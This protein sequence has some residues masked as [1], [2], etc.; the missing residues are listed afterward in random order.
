MGILDAYRIKKSLAVLVAAQDSSSPAVS[1]AVARLKNIGRTSAAKLID[2]FGKAQTPAPLAEVLATFLDNDTFPFFS[3]H[4]THANPRIAE[5][6]TQVFTKST[7]Y[8]AHKLLPLFADPKIPK[9][10]L[11][12][13][14]LA[15][16]DRLNVKTLVA[17]LPNADKDGRVTLLRLLDRSVTEAALP[18]LIQ[19]TRSEDPNIRLNM[20]RILARFHT[21]AVCDALL[22]LLG[23][24]YKNVRQ[25]A[26]EGLAEMSIAIAVAPVCKL[27]RDPE[28]ELQ[29]KAVDVL[30]QRHDPRSAHH[31]LEYLQDSSEPVRRA[32][33]RVLQAIGDVPTIKALLFTTKDK[34]R[35]SRIRAIEALGALEGNTLCEAVFMLLQDQ[36][37]FIRACAIEILTSAKD[38]RAF[39]YLLEALTDKDAARRERAV[40]AL[41]AVGDKRAIPALLQRLQEEPQAN[42]VIIRAL[43]TL[44]ARQAIPPLLTQLHSQNQEVQKETLRAL[45]NLADADSAANVFQAVIGVSGRTDH[46]EIKD[47]AATTAKTLITKF[48][49]KAMTTPSSAKTP[50]A[51]GRQSLLPAEPM[52]P[53]VVVQ[54]AEVE[55][56]PIQAIVSELP[57]DDQ[58]PDGFLDPNAFAPGDVLTERY[59]IIRR[60]GQGGF[61]T[62]MLVED[63]MVGEEIILKFLNPS[64]ASEDGMIKRFVHELRYARRITHEN[65]I[66]IHDFLMLEKSYAISMEYFDSHSLGDELNGGV[67]L[68]IKRGL[69]IV[70]D[71]CRGMSAAH[72]VN[73]VHRD[74]K[75]PNILIDDQGVV[76]VVDFGLAALNHAESRLTRTGIL[77]GT[78]TYMAPEQVRSRS[79]DARTDVYSLGVI[80]YEIF[81]GQP[82]YGGDDPMA[83]LFQHVEGKPKPPRQIQADIPAGLEAV[84]LK[85]MAVDPDKRYQSMDALRRGIADLTKQGGR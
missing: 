27:L 37:E 21:E 23:D 61:G 76:K 1:Q 44:G 9:A 16:Q 40:E 50:T 5:G 10:T 15:R 14:L 30:I 63:M 29:A 41:A 58:V 34:G 53:E 18:E 22:P 82:P 19:A 69:K 78:P 33:G 56:P 55:L 75:P 52:M 26:L 24:S 79:I 70:W 80:M 65:V 17:L 28:P 4:L 25:A 3:T 68:Q 57:A 83:V 2:S 77:L 11:G 81:T 43:N 72:Q 85:A 74:L 62:V 47:L 67:P 64:V 31:L 60:V 20:S 8:D 39:T 32:A 6:M 7:T 66:R 73:V 38:D 51:S 84:I 35:G 48:G 49:E 71:I 46:H 13:C 54:P 45:A 59:R 36:D 12:K 42:P